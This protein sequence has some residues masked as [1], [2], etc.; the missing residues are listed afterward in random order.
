MTASGVTALAK[1]RNSSSGDFPN[2]G[3]CL[4]S[5]H[6]GIAGVADLPNGEFRDQRLPERARSPFTFWRVTGGAL[7]LAVGA[8]VSWRIRRARRRVGEV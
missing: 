5:D 2:E 4:P 7:L 3:R 6:A 1:A 8:L